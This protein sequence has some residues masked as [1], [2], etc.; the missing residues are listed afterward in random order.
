MNFPCKQEEVDTFGLT[1]LPPLGTA[2]FLVA[3]RVLGSHDAPREFGVVGPRGAP[4]L[5]R[6][7]VAGAAEICGRDEGHSFKGKS[8]SVKEQ[9]NSVPSSDVLM[10]S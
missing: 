8:A 9:L 1:F 6:S 2:V 4:P 5:T 7:G 3:P 10:T